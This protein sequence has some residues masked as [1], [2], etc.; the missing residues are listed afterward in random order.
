[1][2]K[3]YLKLFK[4]I[5][6]MLFIFF[7]ISFN[8]SLGQEIVPR[9]KNKYNYTDNISP[10]NLPYPKLNPEIKQKLLEKKYKKALK[11]FQEQNYISALS[12]FFD[13][14][15]HPESKYFEDALAYLAA[16]YLKIGQRNDIKNLV[17]KSINILKS[18]YSICLTI[19]KK[20]FQE[21]GYILKNICK[22]SPI[23][24]YFLG[25]AYE[26]LGFYKQAQIY[27][28]KAL[29]NISKKY[30]KFLPLIKLGL[31]RIALINKNLDKA[32]EYIYSLQYSRLLNPEEK[33][34]LYFLIGYYYFLQGKFASAQKYFNLGI[35]TFKPYLSYNPFIYY[36]V[37]ENLFYMQDYDK[38]LKIFLKLK[39]YLKNFEIVEKSKLRI[40][41]ILF[42][43]DKATKK[44]LTNSYLTLISETQ[45]TKLNYIAKVSEIKFLTLIADDFKL[46]LFY[47]NI[48]KKSKI[49]NKDKLVKDLKDPLVFAATT[50]AKNRN[51]YIGN[52]ALGLFG[53]EVLRG[54]KLYLYD[55]LSKELNY[56]Q[57]D[58]F[59]PEHRQFI[60]KLWQRYLLQ[61]LPSVNVKLYLSNPTFFNNIFS[62]SVLYKIALDLT[63]EGYKQEAIKL[64][65]I[66]PKKTINENLV[67]NSVANLLILGKPKLAYNIL[68]NFPY[69]SDDYLILLGET[70]YKLLNIKNL[71][72]LL[73]NLKKIP[74]KRILAVYYIFK[75]NLDKI[76]HN[77]INKKDLEN[78]KLFLDYLKPKDYLVLG[79][80]L[81]SLGD[82]SL[83]NQNY[84]LAEKIFEKLYN[85]N[86]NSCYTG[87]KLAY[88]Y[89]KENKLKEANELINSI[90][91]S[92]KNP[93]VKLTK[94]LINLKNTMAEVLNYENK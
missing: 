32:K 41:D 47:K 63:H 21:N 58:K 11:Y 23:Y 35:K 64:F 27:Y 81:T 87:M 66:I 5:K 29:E 53:Y 89:Y 7:F 82:I 55:Y 31:L 73:K 78:L 36:T 80:I 16:C 12:L 70:Y 49:K 13:I 61:G 65:T 15:K 30:I 76:E 56:A 8:S 54:D 74:S 9:Y 39:N 88:T 34:E 33:G 6:Y 68:K 72:I 57:I 10:K 60:S 75:I 46:K 48:L 42:Q 18:Y 44:E 91:K 93:Y 25:V 84:A 3:D 45:G 62:P 37:A 52:Y 79:D 17:Q 2:R 22:P 77:K 85:L 20:K 92:C 59:L 51:N 43:T 1:M 90:S 38:A 83:S 40:N 24:Y 67:L 4:I 14:L 71:K 28:K 50:W 19:N 69:K 94:Y 86:Y 26:T